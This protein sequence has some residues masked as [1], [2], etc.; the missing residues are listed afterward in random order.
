MT[1]ILT[2]GLQKS[3]FREYKIENTLQTKINKN[4][5][6]NK[7]FQTR[8]FIPGIKYDSSMHTI[9]LLQNNRPV[10][11]CDT[12]RRRHYNLCLRQRRDDG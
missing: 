1:L 7:K 8:E 9:T 4:L 6:K 3:D 10:Y 11:T 2:S 12:R 5:V